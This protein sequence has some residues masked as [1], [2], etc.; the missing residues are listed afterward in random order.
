MKLFSDLDAKKR[1]MKT[2]L[3]IMIGIAWTP[4]IWMVFTAALG[5]LLFTL[6]GSWAATLGVILLAVL[7]A[8][9]LLLKVFQG[10]SDKF[11]SKDE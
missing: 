4:I 2:G 11:Y 5:P 6:T 9:Y 1:F 7:L 3:P 8:D 10:I